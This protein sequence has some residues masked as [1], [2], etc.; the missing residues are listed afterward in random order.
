M[1]I[2]MQQLHFYNP[3]VS[4]SKCINNAFIEAT[5][6]YTLP[7]L[8]DIHFYKCQFNSDRFNSTQFNELGIEFPD[9]LRSAVKS[10]QSEFLAGRFCAS[11]AIKS[12][13]NSSGQIPIGENRQPMWP[14][15]L[16][17]SISHI[18]TSAICAAAI[19]S[20]Y[21]YLGI[22]IENWI[23]RQVSYEIKDLIISSEEESILKHSDFSDIE[24][25]TLLFSAK[26]SLFKA[27]YKYVG[28]Y[29]GFEAAKLVMLDTK[30]CLLEL[31][32]VENLSSNIRAGKK[33]ICH[34]SLHEKNVFTIVCGN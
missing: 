4:E 17:G 24:S 14:E 18:E 3:K 21:K 23:S 16:L 11:Q 29:F 8:K 19:E 30:K 15:G 20:E 32:I 27:I 5:E 34:F 26:E 12:L 10:R 25:I 7:H 6:S 9:S 13:N 33:F 2:L 28:K 1:E 22:D 31:E